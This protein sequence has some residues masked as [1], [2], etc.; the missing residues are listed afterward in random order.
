MSKKK[1]E[2]PEAEDREFAIEDTD[3]L[4]SVDD[5]LAELKEAAPLSPER[6]KEIEDALAGIKPK[7]TGSPELD[8]LE[9]DIA[10]QD[11]AA[12]DLERRLRDEAMLPMPVIPLVYYRISST[13]LVPALIVC[14][15]D[16]GTVNLKWFGDGAGTPGY[17]KGVLRGLGHGQ[18]RP[19]G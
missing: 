15:N 5:R 4:P 10:R 6:E 12:R 16:D 8:D 3:E 18:Y 1:P 17:A 19:V 13:E 11:D 9:R 14:Q 2:K 7:G